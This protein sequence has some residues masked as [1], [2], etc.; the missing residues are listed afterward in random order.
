[1]TDCTTAIWGGEHKIQM[2]DPHVDSCKN[3]H[4]LSDTDSLKEKINHNFN[5]YRIPVNVFL[6]PKKT[7]VN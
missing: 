4:T 2:M 6:D 1:M 5:R 3:D 7:T